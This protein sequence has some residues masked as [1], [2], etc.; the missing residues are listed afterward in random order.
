MALL[1][2]ARFP[3]PPPALTIDRLNSGRVSKPFPPSTPA[4]REPAGWES[5]GSNRVP[6][7]DLFPGVA[8]GHTVGARGRRDAPQVVSLSAASQSH[9][10]ARQER[11]AKR[12]IDRR[13]RRS[14]PRGRARSGC[15]PRM[16]YIGTLYLTPFLSAVKPRRGGFAERSADVPAQK[17]TPSCRHVRAPLRKASASRLHVLQEGDGERESGLRTFSGD[18][19][20]N[21]IVVHHA[22]G[23]R[24]FNKYSVPIAAASSKSSRS[25]AGKVVISSK[26]DCW[27][28]STAPPRPF[29]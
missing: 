9:C 11:Q 27:P 16:C 8:C 26:S 4:G 15:V 24:T 12:T 20:S 7:S 13:P 19:G 5:L 18:G 3:R 2:P 14:R 17:G 6:M 21:P 28:G 25:P 23:S 1:V 29:N 10:A 22:R